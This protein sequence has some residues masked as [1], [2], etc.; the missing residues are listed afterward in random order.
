MSEQPVLTKDNAR[1][2]S[3]RR[4]VQDQYGAEYD[5]TELL[6]EG[7]QGKVWKTNHQNTLV[8]TFYKKNKVKQE[9]WFNHIQWVLRQ[10][11]DGLAIAAPKALIT[12][13]VPGY[14]MELMEGLHSLTSEMERSFVALVEGK[15][16]NGFL[17]TGGLKRRLQILA[18]LAD[19]LSR[20]HARGM[21]YGD[22]S[23]S[24]I[25]VSENVSDSRVWL[26]DCDNICTNE[27]AGTM[28]LYS[29]GFGAPEVVRGESGVNSLTDAWSFAV[30]AY[31]VL[32]MQHPLIGVMVEDGEPELQEQAYRGEL[33]WVGDSS[34]DCNASSGGIP[35]E[36]VATK[37]LQTLFKRCFEQGKNCSWERPTL[38]EWRSNLDEA[39]SLLMNCHNPKCRSSFHRNK[40]CPFCG[41]AV[42]PDDSVL[43]T[44]L[45]YS[46]DPSL[47][48]KF[49]KTELGQI[50]NIGEVISLKRVPAGTQLYQDSNEVCQIRFDESGLALK[51][52]PG[53]KI[54]LQVDG[55]EQELTK[56][57]VFKPEQ[58]VGKRYFL[59]LTPPMPYE[60]SV[61][62]PVWAFRW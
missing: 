51:I 6:G 8:K 1:T 54:I 58:K 31:Q 28:H 27:R 62:H 18:Q 59:H 40:A 25:F 22:L 49:L 44:A 3:K 10:D 11:L 53:N 12:K 32:T 29:P 55:Q 2:S 36:M 26:I 60:D 17:Q 42:N 50:A 21:A 9:Q 16:L 52:I 45:I 61:T 56:G 13:P 46:A 24:N 33:P 37:K 47:D 48:R 43:F 39:L 5:C 38:T 34:D 41:I 4:V 35:L 57:V 20:L 30:I 14:V 19:T 23:P 15:G 7:G